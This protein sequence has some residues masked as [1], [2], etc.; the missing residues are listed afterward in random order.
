MNYLNLI[1]YKNLLFIAGLQ[2]LMYYCIIIPLLKTF[3]LDPSF[4][5]GNVNFLLLMGST[6]F[7]AASGYVINDYFDTRIDAINRPDKMIVGVSV[8][9]EMASRLHQILTAVGLLLGFWVAYQSR[10][11]AL[12]LIIALV[13]GLLWFYSASYKRQFL[14][15]NLVVALN[16]ALVP[17]V[18]VVATGSFLSSENGYGKLISQTP[19]M[20]VLLVWVLG[21]SV[22]AF[23]ATLI[24]EI[25]KD[26]ED[27]EGDRE[28]ESR[29]LPIVWGASKSKIVLYALIAIT[30]AL[31]LFAHH[32][33]I[34]NFP[35][36]GEEKST[37]SLR[38]ILF[39]I[40]L[41]LAYLV[42]LI[43][44]AK[45]PADFHQAASFN[46]FIMILASLFALVFYYLLAKG[47]G[48]AIFDI[49]M[50]K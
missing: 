18:V 45:V 25:I 48:I 7:L 4:A 15:G 1:R 39:G 33:F 8:S 35:L 10:S 42:F 28:M 21:F 49:F 13:P 9:K 20:S 34:A 23:I 40:L 37:L 27:V 43:A 3:A 22:F 19:V 46:K 2:W 41:P 6:L 30:A 17:L 36:F 16:A 5:L 12:A 14:V 24:R 47:Q 32:S 29:T 44:K 38:Y 50:V 31:L 26:I 11:M